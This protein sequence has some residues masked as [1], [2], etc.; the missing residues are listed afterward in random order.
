MQK[1]SNVKWIEITYKDS[2]FTA[3]IFRSPCDKFSK[4]EKQLMQI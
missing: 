2:Y 1:D 3:V 4:F